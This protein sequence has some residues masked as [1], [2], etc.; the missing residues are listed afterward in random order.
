MKRTAGYTLIFVIGVIAL[1]AG[2]AAMLAGPSIAQQRRVDLHYRKLQVEYMSLAGI[3][4]AHV[5]AAEGIVTNALYLLANGTVDVKM[6]PIE[7]KQVR[8]T[9]VGRIR[10][11]W[12]KDL[13]E[14]RNEV[15]IQ[16]P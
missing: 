8:V 3:E 6:E 13:I 10:A 14:A 12:R 2:L 11:E 4:R 9:S 1:L 16:L 7:G 15:T 5:W